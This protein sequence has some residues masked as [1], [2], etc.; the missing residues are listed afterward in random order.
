M[1]LSNYNP[2]DVLAAMARKEYDLVLS[3]AL[4]HARDGNSDA[5]TTVALL[6]E[7]GLGVRR[8][9]LEAEQWLLKA[10]EQ[11][12]AL[13]WN[14]LGTLYASRLPELRKHW[15]D[16]TACYEKAKELGLNVADPYPPP[17]S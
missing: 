16:A 2:D 3:L 8:D 15:E 6:Y 4:P 10:A 13:A 12:N 11:N 9:V 5:Q 7:C 14:N 17:V 1:K